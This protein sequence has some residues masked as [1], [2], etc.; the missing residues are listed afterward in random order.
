[1]DMK[2]YHPLTVLFDIIGFFKNFGILAVILFLNKGSDSTFFHIMGWVLLVSFVYTVVASI[3]KLFTNR[4]GT[5]ERA[6]HLKSG[7][8][9]KTERTIN[10]EKIQNVQRYTSFLHKLLRMTSITF[11]TGTS[12][13]N[14]NVPFPVLTRSEADRLESLVKRTSHPVSQNMNDEPQ[15]DGG[16]WNETER[17][18]HFTPTHQDLVKA[19]F[20]SLSFLFFLAIASSLLAKIGA[21]FHLEDTAEGW[22]ESILSSGWMI[23]GFLAI[24]IMLSISV[25]ILI[26]FVK[27]GKYEIASDDKRIYI[28]KGVLDETAFSIAKDRVQAVEITQSFMK[29]LLGLAEVKLISIGDLGDDD[30]EVSTLY[31]FLPMQRTYSI[32][33]ELLPDYEVCQHMKKLPRKSLA[34]RLL[35]PYWFWLIA[36]ILLVY[37]KPALLDF[38]YGWAIASAVLLAFIIARRLIVYHNTRY[39]LTGSQIQLSQ[40]MFEKTT[41]ITRRDK[42]AEVSVKRSK[43]QQWMGLATIGFINRA[44]P[45]RYESLSDIPIQD[46]KRFYQWYAKR[47]TE[48]LLK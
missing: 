45:V 7:I 37:F 5:D 31:P 1:M 48:V 44:K 28:S 11:E 14:A 2:H 19:S 24:V 12:G 20:T 36:T 21:L 43:L 23:A 42:I 27:Y 13:V 30:N 38:T 29:R 10:Y 22:V 26:T 39:A 46:A 35:K 4:Y 25:G 15:P 9:E 16:R 3:W 47:V 32:I 8:F 34:T 33:S 18:I 40:G 6:F 41:F 17:V